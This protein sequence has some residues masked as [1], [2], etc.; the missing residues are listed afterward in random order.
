MNKKYNT[1]YALI[2]FLLAIFL[3]VEGQ[4]QQKKKCRN[5]TW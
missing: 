1:V 2:L 3:S 4:A 5:P